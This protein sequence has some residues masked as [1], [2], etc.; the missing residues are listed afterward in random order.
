MLGAQVDFARSTFDDAKHRGAAIDSA[1][2]VRRL[3][4]H[5]VL[6]VATGDRYIDVLGSDGGM[7]FERPTVDETQRRRIAGPRA[8]FESHQRCRLCRR[9]LR[10]ARVQRKRSA[11]GAYTSPGF[12]HIR[13]PKAPDLRLGAADGAVVFAADS[14]D[15]ILAAAQNDACSEA[16]ACQQRAGGAE[17]RFDCHLVALL[18]RRTPGN[19]QSEGPRIA[20]GGLEVDVWIAACFTGGQKKQDNQCARHPRRLLNPAAMRKR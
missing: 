13:E 11:E 15:T 4:V 5:V 20:A 17:R 1:G 7:R 2:R 16:L 14:L 19:I 9:H 3:Q 6:A 10:A 12:G 8:P 18:A